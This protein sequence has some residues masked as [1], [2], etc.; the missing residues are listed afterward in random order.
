[1]GGGGPSRGAAAP[2]G[3]R[4][5]LR[6]IIS[7]SG[8]LVWAR[9][10]SKEEIPMKRFGVLVVIA[11]A[12][13]LGAPR[14]ACA[15]GVFAQLT[16]KA[17]ES[18]IPSDFYLEGNRIPVEKRNAVLLKTPGGA[19]LVL[20]L[21]DTSGYSTQIQQ[22]YIGMVITEGAVSVC[23]VPLNVGSYGFGLEKPAGTSSG[24]AKFHLYN[25]AGETVGDCAAKKDSAVKQPK[26]LNVVLSK[27]AGARLYLGRYVLELK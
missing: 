15:Q 9:V 14:S 19:R 17:V 10:I 22:K 3:F 4:D 13:L 2:K 12:I 16:G 18:A 27:E 5:R 6:L 1:L 26:P 24:D 21:I 20:A 11:L 7:I 8:G 25:Q 23:S